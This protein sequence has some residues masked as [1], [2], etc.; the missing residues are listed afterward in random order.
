MNSSSQMLEKKSLNGNEILVLRRLDD[1]QVKCQISFDGLCDSKVWPKCC[2]FHFVKESELLGGPA[3]RRD[4][5]RRCVKAGADF[6]QFR[7]IGYVPIIEPAEFEVPTGRRADEH[8]GAF[9]YFQQTE[10]CYAG[11]SLAHR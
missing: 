3:Y 1:R 7:G 8:A 5:R 10:R 11:N 4:T 2:L 9:S 6:Q